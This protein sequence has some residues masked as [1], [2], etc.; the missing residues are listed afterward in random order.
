MKTTLLS[1]CAFFLLLSAANA[2]GLEGIIVEKFYVSDAADSTDA[3]DN[4]AVSPLRIGSV[5]Y[6]VYADLLPGYEVIQIFGSTDHE[7]RF[8]T[9]TDFYNDPN[10]GFTV[11]QGTSVNNTR[12]NTT[13][14]DSYLTIGGVASGLLGVPKEEDTDGTIGNLQGILANADASAGLPITGVG[15]ADG[16]MPG[17]PIVPNT[18]GLTTELDVFDQTAG[19]LFSTNSG[20]IAAL[21]GMSG[22]TAS[23]RVLLG[24]FTTSGTFSFK[25]NLQ[26][27]TPVAGESEVYVAENVGAGELTDSTLVFTSEED[28]GGGIN[29]LEVNT[30]ASKVS[31]YPNPTSELLNFV[32]SGEHMGNIEWIITD[33]SGREWMQ[34]NSA[35]RAQ[36]L[37]VNALPAGA[38]ILVGRSNKGVTTAPFLKQ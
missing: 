30:K 29:V 16:L 10:F 37:D 4:F 23:N 11:Y 8:E 1:I 7:L 21:G 33:L 22:V 28:N 31:V 17:T 27:G 2:Q 25:L 5:T 34:W 9:T 32:Y 3:A 36:R 12:K 18:L 19:S 14:I 13:L 35:N 24:Q 15:A 38:Y 20:T 6:R 26:L